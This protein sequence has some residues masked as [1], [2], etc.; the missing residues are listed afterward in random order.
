[1]KIRLDLLKA[2][3]LEIRPVKSVIRNSITNVILTILAFNACH[4]Y[5]YSQTERNI[6]VSPLSEMPSA[7]R[8]EEEISTDLST[9]SEFGSLKSPTEP[10]PIFDSQWIEPIDWLTVLRLSGENHLDIA[11]ARERVAFA[12]ADL[13]QSQTLLLPSLYFGPNWIRHDGQ[14]QLVDG[15]IK[16]ISKSSL[17]LG[18][19]AAAG[20][21]IGGPVPAGGPAQVGGLTSIIRFSDAIFEPMANRQLLEARR[22]GVA[23]AQQNAL[24]QCS[25]LYLDLQDAM[26]RLAIAREAAS[27]SADLVRITQSYFDSGKGLEADLRRSKTELERRRQEVEARVSTLEA[28]SAELVRWL[29]LN[30]NSILAPVEPPEMLIELISPEIPTDELIILGLT[31]RPELAESQAMVQATIARLKQA[32]LRPYIPSLAFRYSGG[33]FGGGPNGYFGNFDGR[34]DADVNLYWQLQGLGF[35]DRAIKRKSEAENRM[36]EL[37]LLKVQDRVASEVASAHRQLLANRRRRMAAARAIPDARESVL[38]NFKAIRQGAGLSTGIRAIETLQPIQA[39]A[40]VENEL[41]S[42]CI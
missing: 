23:V 11:I 16:P 35:A 5:V 41:L 17:F 39:L 18:S 36:A 31:H 21:G 15:V 1:M 10:E 13:H 28:T 30:Q 9:G 19:T 25:E 26:G 32:K 2:R 8:V 38:M 4:H 3:L 33:A 12:V 24:L 42:S 7:I 34:S 27:L 29:R 6:E 37:E 14:T 20:S 40:D 22:A